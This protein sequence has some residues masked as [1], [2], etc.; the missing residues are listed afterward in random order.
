MRHARTLLV[1]LSIPLG[2]ASVGCTHNYYY[3]PTTPGCPPTTTVAPSAVKYGAVCEVPTQVVGGATVVPG[4]PV[5]SAP[6]LNG[7][8][9]PRVVLSEPG[10]GSVLGWRRADPESGLATTRVEG[11]AVDDPTLTR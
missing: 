6:V 10:G 5:V 8:R 7:P 2:A 3:Y 11:G 1:G 4:T 9:P